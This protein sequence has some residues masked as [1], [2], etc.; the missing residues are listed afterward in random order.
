MSFCGLPGRLVDGGF[1]LRVLASYVNS[2][3]VH[4]GKDGRSSTQTELRH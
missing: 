3:I 4:E 1:E 2:V